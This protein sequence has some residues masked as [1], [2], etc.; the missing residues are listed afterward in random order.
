MGMFVKWNESAID[1]NNSNMQDDYMT[2]MEN[3]NAFV[4]NID[5]NKLYEIIYEKSGKNNSKK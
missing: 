1:F 4:D 3:I 2:A 5:T